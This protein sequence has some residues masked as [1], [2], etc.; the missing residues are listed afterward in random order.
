MWEKDEPIGK[1]IHV[2]ELPRDLGK[3]VGCVSW[4]KAG[5]LVLGRKTLMEISVEVVGWWFSIYIFY[6]RRESNLGFFFSSSL[7]CPGQNLSSNVFHWDMDWTQRVVE[8]GYTHNPKLQQKAQLTVMIYA[9]GF[10]I[11]KWILINPEPWETLH[12]GVW[13]AAQMR[14]VQQE[15]IS[16]SFL[17]HPLWKSIIH[18]QENL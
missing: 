12:Q 17:K 8:R 16:E 2:K 7:F 13:G 4:E 9:M 18:S 11:G 5:R 10:C 15:G 14:V 1:Q 3:N 6:V